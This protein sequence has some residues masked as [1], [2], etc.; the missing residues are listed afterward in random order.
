MATV[1]RLAGDTKAASVSANAAIAELLAPDSRFPDDYRKQYA[2]AHAYAAVDDR[3]NTIK[4]AELGLA[5]APRDAVENMRDEY[6]MARLLALVGEEERAL[7]LLAPLL[8]GP[9]DISLSYVE[10]DPHWDGLRDDKDFNAL[11]DRYRDG[12]F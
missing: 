5:Q 3:A 11:L 6:H 1:F 2:L 10:L 4:Y 8:P 12:A 7:E 9:S